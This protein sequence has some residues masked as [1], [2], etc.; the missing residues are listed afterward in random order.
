MR[1]LPAGTVVGPVQPAFI[2][3]LDEL[4]GAGQMVE[5]VDWASPANDSQDELPVDLAL[6]SLFDP[7]DDSDLNGDGKNIE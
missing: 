6:S 5:M 3:V 7:L 1:Q 2:A 4:E